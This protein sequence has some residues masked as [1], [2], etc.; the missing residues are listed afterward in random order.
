MQNHA[1]EI[2][3]KMIKVSRSIDLRLAMARRSTLPGSR[4]HSQ[5]DMNEM[6]KAADGSSAVFI[7]DKQRENCCNLEYRCTLQLNIDSEFPC[8]WRGC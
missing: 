7:I 4:N 1:F 6:R 2:L 8:W 5:L 3:F